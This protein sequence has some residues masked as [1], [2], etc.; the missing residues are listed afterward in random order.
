MKMRRRSFGLMNGSILGS[1]KESKAGLR[2][3][4]TEYS[5]YCRVFVL[6]LEALPISAL[7]GL[8]ITSQCFNMI[9]KPV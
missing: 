1:L 2:D 9:D 7:L 6:R 5:A 8:A 3:T 4:S